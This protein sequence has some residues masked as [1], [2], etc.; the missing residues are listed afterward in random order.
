VNAAGNI[1]GLILSAGASRRM[2]SPKA[3]LPF[4]GEVFLD[5]LIRLFAEVCDPVIVVLGYDAQSIRDGMARG[6]EAVFAINPDP[7]RGMLSSLQC[8]LLQ[9]PADCAGVLFTPVDHPAIQAGTLSA[10]AQALRDAR[11]PVVKPAYRGRT[12]H[13]VGISRDAAAELLA[14][15]VLDRATSVLSG[16]A[17]GAVIIETADPGILSDIDDPAAY[18]ALLAARA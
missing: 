14:L 1:A 17:Q 7:G 2:G 9:V 4:G 16:R 11:A 15:P 12:G 3:L 18:Q 5:R 10:L 13:P 6:G 8:G